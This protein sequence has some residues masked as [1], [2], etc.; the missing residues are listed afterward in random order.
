MN[1]VI[2]LTESTGSITFSPDFAIMYSAPNNKVRIL[3][4]DT[5]IIIREYEFVLTPDLAG[6]SP[7]GRLVYGSERA[8]NKVIVINNQGGTLE[9]GYG[10][11]FGLNGMVVG[12]DGQQLFALTTEQIKD[13]FSVAVIDALTQQLVKKI[14]VGR[15]AM[16][17]A[18]NPVDSKLWVCCAGVTGTDEGVYV[19]DPQTESV[20][21][22]SVDVS[23]FGGIV[24][25]AKNNLAYIFRTLSSDTSPS[26]TPKPTR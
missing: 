13:P 12:L 7:D 26:L 9:P 18:I 1:E 20:T 16:A 17:I 22:I 5:Q 15:I 2:R 8:T 4:A 6:T 21:H 3:R 24:L 10:V 14:P 19:V 11:G 23:V 25:D